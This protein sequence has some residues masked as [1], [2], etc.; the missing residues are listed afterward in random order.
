MPSSGNSQRSRP[1]QPAVFQ[2][3]TSQTT[4]AKRRVTTG[5]PAESHSPILRQPPTKAAGPVRTPRISAIPARVSPRASG[6][7]DPDAPCNR[8]QPA[9]SQSQ[10]ST[11]RSANQMGANRTSART[12]RRSAGSGKTLSRAP[13][14]CC[15]SI[16]SAP[17]LPTL[18]GSM[19]RVGD[20]W[21]VDPA[22]R[23]GFSGRDG[24]GPHLP[25]GM[26]GIRGTYP[27]G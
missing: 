15:R 12:S 8:N 5:T 10:P 16:P 3:S 1:I 14:I 6:S 24:V 7:P 9:S 19:T 22:A 25:Q 26:A 17:A 4:A 23:G 11:T 18:I 21:S 20:P 2:A 13:L 27:L